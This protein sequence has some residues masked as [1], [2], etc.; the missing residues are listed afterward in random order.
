[1]IELASQTSLTRMARCSGP[2]NR[3]FFESTLPLEPLL[4]RSYLKS[5]LKSYLRTASSFVSSF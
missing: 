3:M 4:A 5:Y 1:M 2:E